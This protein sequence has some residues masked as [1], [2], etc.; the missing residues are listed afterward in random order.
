MLRR[1]RQR[2]RTVIIKTK[3]ITQ[4]AFFS[5]FDPIQGIVKVVNPFL[6]QIELFRGLSGGVGNERM[7]AVGLVPYKLVKGNQIIQMFGF[8]SSVLTAN[9][10]EHGVRIA[11]AA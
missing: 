6:R 2:M 10:V 9:V 3:A 1:F 11:G 5:L 4:I 7:F 8:K